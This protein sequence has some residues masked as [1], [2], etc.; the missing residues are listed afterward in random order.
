MIEGAV[1]VCKA[2]EALLKKANI[3]GKIKDVISLSAGG[4]NRIYEVKTSSGS[5]AAK[6][7][8]RHEYDKRDR[9]ATEYAFANYAAD[10]APKFVSRPYACIYEEGWAL[11]DYLEGIHIGPNDINK[12]HVDQAIN[13]FKALNN[14]P[15][16]LTITDKSLPN[17]SEACFTIQEHLD[18]VEN[19]IF[20]LQQSLVV[21]SFQNNIAIEFLEKLN[22]FW[23]S[24]SAEITE[25]AKEYNILNRSL[26][27]NQRC[28]S[29]S[30]FGFHNAL[31]Q[32]NGQIK[33]IDF[34]YA[35]ID[36][37]AKMAGDFFA[38]LAVPIPTE[39]FN[40]FVYE[41][42]YAFEKPKTLITRAKLMRLVYQV[43]WCC[44]AM[45]VF[46]PINLTRR[47]FANPFLDAAKLK[48]IQLNKAV[49][50]FNNFKQETI[51]G[52]H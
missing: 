40:E 29:P 42:M 48:D 34:E 10:V 43:K 39:Y 28:I 21:K 18:L 38:Q 52:I 1:D 51:N 7:Y 5:F 47:K 46:L 32:S 30:D 49:Q 26:D 13:F 35:G 41:T 36:D 3:K 19:R 33:F 31:L 17:A 50:L 6:K 23:V 8:F 2:L 24:I 22:E 14:T 12:Q 20:K 16:R 15:S 37:P 27:Q 45:N 44:I 9:L 25:K 11:Y 4:N